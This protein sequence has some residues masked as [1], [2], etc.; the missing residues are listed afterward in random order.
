MQA[1]WPETA[2]I[3]NV[4][5]TGVMMVL[6]LPLALQLQ[7]VV[8]VLAMLLTENMSNSCKNFLAADRPMEKLLGAL[9]ADLAE[10]M[11]NL[12]KRT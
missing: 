3:D 7:L 11:I 12:R 9:R 8:S 4:V 2:P 1:I 6:E 5:P 10:A